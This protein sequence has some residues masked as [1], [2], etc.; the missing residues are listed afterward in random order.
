MH[1]FR[2]NLKDKELEELIPRPSL[3]VFIVVAFG[4]GASL[5]YSYLQAL[6]TVKPMKCGRCKKVTSLRIT[7]R[8]S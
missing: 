8:K 1:C 7:Y 5:F 3:Y 4:L 6:L 2:V